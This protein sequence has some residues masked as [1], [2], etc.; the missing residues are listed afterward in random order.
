MATDNVRVMGYVSPETYAKL[1]MFMDA[2]ALTE[3]QAIDTILSEYLG[4]TPFTPD[5]AMY[6]GD[7][8]TEEASLNTQPHRPAPLPAVSGD[9]GL[10]QYQLA[11]RLKCEI[12]QLES[13]RNYPVVLS[14]YTRDRDPEGKAWEYEPN[15]QQFFPLR[16]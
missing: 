2:R 15:S 9:E 7:S 8:H 14:D 6:K 5:L 3:L 13:I 10:S 4:T 16:Q 12:T 1:R 11:L